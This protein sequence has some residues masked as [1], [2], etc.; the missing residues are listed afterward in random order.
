MLMRQG[1]RNKEP[2]WLLQNL[3]PNYHSITD[4][5]KLHAKPLQ[6][7]FKIYV[8]ILGNAG[9]LYKTTIGIDGSKFKR[10]NRKNSYKKKKTDKH[11]QYIKKK[12][13]RYLLEPNELDKEEN[14]PGN[15]KLQIIKERIGRCRVKLRAHP[16][17]YRLFFTGL[18]LSN[19]PA[20]INKYFY[21]ATFCCF[22][23]RD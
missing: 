16:E 9:L 22:K 20:A 13:E 12:T 7:V 2:Q 6:A 14:K 3:Q 23:S 19:S 15:D 1:S 8:Q 4:F 17:Y 11:Q 18:Y 10:V 21:F 5:C